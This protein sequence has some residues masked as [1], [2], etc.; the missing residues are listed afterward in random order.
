S[1]WRID[2]NE[3]A[4]YMDSLTGRLQFQNQIGANG[5]NELYYL[6]DR[7]RE[8]PKM[9]EDC[10]VFVHGDATPDNFLFG[11]GLA[12]ISFDLERLKRADRVFDTGRVAAELMHFF[13]LMTGNK[14][15]A[16]P[17]I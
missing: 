10:Q 4:A 1:G 12:V 3:A 13:L 16:E 8:Q 17:F 2:F 6:R 7:W 9:W 14:Y 11:D 15:A 5:A